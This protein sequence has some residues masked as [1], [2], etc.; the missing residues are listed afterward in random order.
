VHLRI[1]GV[2]KGQ[3]AYR[4]AVEGSLVLLSFIKHPVVR[5]EFLGV[6]AHLLHAV[7]ACAALVANV[8]LVFVGNLLVLHQLLHFPELPAA[9]VAF[10]FCKKAGHFAFLP[11]QHFRHIWPSIFHAGL[12][13]Y[14]IKPILAPHTAQKFSFLL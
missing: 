11:S 5:M 2:P 12:G 13:L 3:A 6:V 7:K 1:S 14:R 8:L 10:M 4:K 9:L